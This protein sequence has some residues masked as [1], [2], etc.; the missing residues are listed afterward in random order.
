MKIPKEQIRHILLNL[1]KNNDTN[2][3]ALKIQNVYEKH[4]MSK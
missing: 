3:T 2:E 4:V 1:L